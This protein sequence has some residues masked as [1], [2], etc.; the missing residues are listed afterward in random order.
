MIRAARAL[1]SA[2]VL[3]LSA[4]GAGAQQDTPRP[5]SR[6]TQAQPAPRP[7]LIPPQ[8]TPAPQ[9]DKS[10]TLP[11]SPLNPSVVLA[12]PP[13]FG[14]ATPAAQ[15]PRQDMACLEALRALGATFTVPDSLP[16]PEDPACTIDHPVALTTIRPGVALHGS[17]T[18]DCQIGLALAT[19]TRDF[20]EPAAAHWAA[21]GHGALTGY[22]LGSTYACRQRVGDGSGKM[23]EHATGRAIDIATFTFADSP[24]VPVAPRTEDNDMA[25][26]FQAAARGTACI[27]FTT[28]LGP[29]SD[30]AHEDHLHL[31]IKPRNG[32][33][34][35]CQ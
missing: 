2:M 11:L 28:V 22:R 5:P 15:A 14:P 31:D 9:Q 8:A 35:I 29:G 4:P 25:Q 20:V 18:V 16:P 34:R 33:Y 24:D 13:Q 1:G 10:H 27:L 6:P 7:A 21:Q 23:S 3:A 19:W 26:A 12:S 17:A 30:G 32:G